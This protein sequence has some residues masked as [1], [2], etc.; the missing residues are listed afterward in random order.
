MNILI[1]LAILLLSLSSI[2]AETDVCVRDYSPPEDRGV[3]PCEMGLGRY[4]YVMDL[5][6]SD[7]M[8][9]AISY[10]DRHCKFT[11]KEFDHVRNADGEVICVI[12]FHQPPISAFCASHPDLYRWT[13]SAWA[14]EANLMK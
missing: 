11:P 2:A 4:H 12:N 13:K 9:C 14:D 6:E 5:E 10:E 3:S 7:N 1:S 8:I